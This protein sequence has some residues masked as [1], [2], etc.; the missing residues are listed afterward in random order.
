MLI[1]RTD[2]MSD[3]SNLH[4][5]YYGQFVTEST[6]LFVVSR[7]GLDILRSS[8]CPHFNDVIRHN[9]PHNWVWDYAPVDSTKMRECGE[10]GQN[11]L[12]SW[13]SITCV[14]KEAARQ[15]LEEELVN[16]NPS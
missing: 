10:I 8:S 16:G 9:G 2:Y 14:A 15:L 1:T 4:R 7:I 12:P 11:S 13:S 3:S 6:K 5:T